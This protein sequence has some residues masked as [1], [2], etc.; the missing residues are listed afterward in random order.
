MLIN[1]QSELLGAV[2]ADYPG[3]S[4]LNSDDTLSGRKGSWKHLLNLHL[5]RKHTVFTFF[6]C[7][8]GLILE[9]LVEIMEG[10]PKPSFDAI[11]F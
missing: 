5:Y 8:F 10:R 3:S 1:E 4:S 9:K 6:I 11:A 7:L 2:I